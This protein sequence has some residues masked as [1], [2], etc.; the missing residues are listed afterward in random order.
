MGRFKREL[1]LM[2]EVD[3]GEYYDVSSWAQ[4]EAG[5]RDL[6]VEVRVEGCSVQPARAS[7]HWPNGWGG[8]R[9]LVGVPASFTGAFQCFVEVF[10]TSGRLFSENFQL[11]HGEATP[12]T[13]AR[14]STVLAGD[15]SL[16]SD[17]QLRQ[18]EAAVVVSAGG[19]TANAPAPSAAAA[20]PAAAASAS[21]AQP[22]PLARGSS[23]PAATSGFGG[24]AA[25]PSF[26]TPAATATFA[27]GG[28][29]GRMQQQ[30]PPPPPLQPA[31][32][33]SAVPS[34]VPA[35]PPPPTGDGNAAAAVA[36]AAS[37]L[38]AAIASAGH[39]AAAPDHQA[40]IHEGQKG[41]LAIGRRRADP[42]EPALLGTGFLVQ[43]PR[44]AAG[45]L[46][47][48]TCAHVVLDAYYDHAPADGLDPGVDGLAVGVGIGERIQWVCRADVLRI[49]RP[50]PAWDA[51]L[52]RNASCKDPG[53]QG[54]M[55]FGPLEPDPATG[56]QQRAYRQNCPRCNM[57][58]G[59]CKGPAPAHWT[60]QDATADQADRL[61][62]AVLQLTDRHGSPLPHP[63][64]LEQ[65]WAG[66]PIAEPVRALT[67]GRSQ[68]LR[69]GEHLI[70]LGYGQEG[71]AV[72][73][74]TSTT[75]VGTFAGHEPQTATGSWLKTHL[76]ILSGHSGGPVLRANG[77]VVGWAVK[78]LHIGHLRPVEALQAALAQ[79]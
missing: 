14:R 15:R 61:D 52:C 42:L 63:L 46:S 66:Q 44:A 28:A 70:M 51:N 16:V 69:D 59:R 33:A 37:A 48:V 57:L 4:V 1:Q 20:V 39:A 54:R 67:L 53:T 7:L 41:V 43:P 36:A 55:R 3:N 47:L 31:A 78:S 11:L 10:S 58:S 64:A 5:R 21:P 26:G 45:A 38:V 49:S 18:L 60:V 50:S 76:R 62:L 73:D 8:T 74:A 27:F 22:P 71:A 56:T 24:A 65:R 6:T 12:S 30:Q 40:V 9:H 23:A 32:S 17:E 34:A 13:A 75:T 29:A 19:A 77:E 35:W 68:T 72:A 79:P 25:T 2:R